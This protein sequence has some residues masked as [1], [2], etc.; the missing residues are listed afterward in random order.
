MSAITKLS[1]PDAISNNGSNDSNCGDKS[2][3]QGS[4]DEDS[5]KVR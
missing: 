4:S 2:S 3:D 1:I 5:E